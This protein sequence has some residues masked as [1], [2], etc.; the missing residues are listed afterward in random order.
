MLG[1]HKIGSILQRNVQFNALSA[2]P[3]SAMQY[4]LHKHDNFLDFDDHTLT[5]Y[6]ED[7]T[8]VGVLIHRAH[9]ST[10]HEH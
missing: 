7:S 1:W 10:Q 4:R 6:Y 9:T 3:R 2:C 8:G 5:L